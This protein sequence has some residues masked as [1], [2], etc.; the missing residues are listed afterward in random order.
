M[1]LRRAGLTASAGFSCCITLHYI[2]LAYRPNLLRFKIKTFIAMRDHTVL[3]GGQKLSFILCYHILIHL[4]LNTHSYSLFELSHALPV[5]DTV[6]KRV[7]SFISKCVNSDCDLVSFSDRHAVVLESSV[8]ERH[9]A[10]FLS[11]VDDGPTA[12]GRATTRERPC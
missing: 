7:L 8:L 6:C 4:I 5:Y 9:H 3:K 12:E 11:S 10:I 2:T 1:L